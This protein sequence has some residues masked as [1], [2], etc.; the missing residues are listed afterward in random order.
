ML[1]ALEAEWSIRILLF[2]DFGVA[3]AAK[4]LY[5]MNYAWRFLKFRRAHVSAVY[6]FFLT[7]II[8]AVRAIEFGKT[9]IR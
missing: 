1:R 9:N 6:R 8:A 3:A 5:E 4:G 7:A 2:F